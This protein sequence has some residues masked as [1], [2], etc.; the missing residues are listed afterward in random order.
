MEDGTKKETK[1][2]K[3]YNVSRYHVLSNVHLRGNK[4]GIDRTTPNGPSWSKSGKDYRSPET[5]IL[6]FDSRT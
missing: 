3:P 1:K 6:L 4:G 5:E 2:R